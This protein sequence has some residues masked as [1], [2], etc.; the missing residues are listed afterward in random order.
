MNKNKSQILILGNN[1]VGK[2][3][4]SY[5]LNG[6]E[7]LPNLE[8]H[9]NLQ[10]DW[11]IERDTYK[12]NVD[13]KERVLLNEQSNINLSAIN[14]DVIV[15]IL[16][17][18]TLGNSKTQ[19]NN[20]IEN[21]LREI[22]DSSIVILLFNEDR[23][24]NSLVINEEVHK[25]YSDKIREI[26]WCNLAKEDF[27]DFKYLLEDIVINSATDRLKYARQIIQDNLSRKAP[28]LDIGNCNITN[29]LEVEEVF[30]CVHL[31]ELI[32][33]NEWAEYKNGK[34][35]KR[36]SVNH[37]GR[38]S[39]GN[40]PNEIS[41][42]TQLKSLISGG[43][44]NDGKQ[45]WNRWNI[46][47]IKP[48]LKLTQLEYLNLSNNVIEVIPSLKRLRKLR[49]LHLNN[50]YI[51]KITNRTNI[52]LLDELYLSNNNI[53]SV[54]FLRK[55]PSVNTIDIHGN[56]IKNLSSIK[57]IIERLNVS[58][59]K[60]EQNTINVSKN[61]LEQP[62]MEIVNISK[63][64]V[65]NYFV[66]ITKGQTYVNKDVKLILV[67]N[68]EVGK[69]TLAKYLN[70]EI[71]LNEEHA[72]THWMD[73]LRLKSKHIISKLNEK[74]NINLF[75]FGGHDYFHDTH[76]LFFG[77]NTMYLLVWDAETNRLNSR[78]VGQLNEKDEIE[79]VTT[80][81]Y[82]LKYWLDAIKY[83]TKEKE[84]ENFDFE[85]DKS[86]EYSSH[87]VIVQNKVGSIKDIIH[88][89]NAE[90]T[91]KYSFIYDFVNISL[92]P[93][94]NLNHLDYA[95]T[96]TLNETKI[97]GVKL[98]RYYGKIKESIA[99]YEGKPILSIS[100]F[101]RYC[102]SVANEIISNERATYL[103]NYLNQIGTIL[104]KPTS[105]GE[106]KVYIN[107]KWVIKKIHS[108]LKGLNN[109]N[110]EFDNNHLKL[111]WGTTVSARESGDIIN[112]MQ[113][114][115]I[116]F[117]H[118]DS[119]KFIAPLYLP[120]KP[121]SSVSLFID[122]NKKP[123]RKI[124]YIGFIHK[125]VILNFFQEYGKLVIKENP[126]INSELFYYW[127]NGL[128]IRDLQTSEIVM[129]QFHL[130]ENEGNASI[131]I[132]K[133][134]VDTQTSFVD[135]II[136]Y[137]HK[138]N[139]GYETQEMITKN[140]AEF[141]PL[142]VIHENEDKENWIFKYNETYYKLGDFKEHF[143]KVNKMKK[144][145][146]SY[147]KQDLVLVNKFIDHLSAL[148]QDGK[149]SS[150]YCTE[151]RA[152]TEWDSEIHKHFEESDIACFMISP[153]FMR[154]QYIHDHEI[155]KAFER[156]KVDSSFKII[157][158][159]LDFCRWS[160]ERNNLSQFT[161]LPYT[162]KPIVDFDNQN[163]AWYIVEECLRLIIEEDIDNRGDGI[164][165]NESLPQDI[166]KIYEEIIV[167]ND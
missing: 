84:S 113:E 70:D 155:A 99:S 133:L 58:D 137:L 108:I 112:L 14:D 25:N 114:F 21:Y 124:R 49:V 64:A 1:A 136:S 128:V 90:L 146:I 103:A 126:T 144:I 163:K 15:I 38:N 67:G 164:Y 153:N 120:R 145:F 130:G 139:K 43:D 141:I 135:G 13:V 119:N 100:E 83:Y 158:I 150:W 56:N 75:D 162:A 31:K 92:K 72:P 55:F 18:P 47:N 45:R 121:T 134:N 69:S 33:S 51:S 16:I 26:I 122:S 110:G 79:Q 142:S 161:A 167:G 87:V 52:E 28:K 53:K 3:T 59:T 127:K 149:V 30:K 27:H 62:P 86:S 106:G 50:N 11:I 41:K 138:I 34:W 131:D 116:I 78:N 123:Y 89:N 74:C 46:G 29:L 19:I 152:G 57:D 61:P 6:N 40:L 35:H 147:S 93:K 12:V 80:Q 68:S 4:L 159:I 66:D 151:L 22:P 140:G 17:R 132:V 8:S 104:Y 148:K 63:A 77:N 5:R 65:L 143:R 44:W 165:K 76:H 125:N 117:T 60:W 88:L 82:P 94:C 109:L 129:I 48:I 105:E 2:T 7:R 32:L 102:T 111:V 91:S 20:Q 166:K 85:M 71:G 37:E 107:K 39:I 101:R 42:L 156:K 95:V 98:P 10:T 81:D 118:P 154:T 54:S 36:P 23:N 9:R 24:E 97:L 73:E 115:K 160:T 96:E 157:P